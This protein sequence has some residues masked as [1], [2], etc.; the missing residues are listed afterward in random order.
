MKK[1]AIKITLSDAQRVILNKLSKATH[2][3]NH[4]KIRATIILYAADETT[5]AHIAEALNITRGMLI[6]WRNRWF[7]ISALLN[8]IEKTTHP[9]FKKEIE[10]ALND[11]YRSGAPSKFTPEEIARIIEI[12]LQKPETFD[13]EETHWTCEALARKVIELNIVNS[14]SSTQVWRFLKAKRF[15]TLPI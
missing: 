4:Y 13:V 8:Q 11:E 5:N 1:E 9:I 6:T 12:S 7:K 3:A 14:I 2:G 10:K 15:E